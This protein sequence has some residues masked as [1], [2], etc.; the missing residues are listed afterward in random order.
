MYIALTH[1]LLYPHFPTYPV[2]QKYILILYKTTIEDTEL[3]LKSK[4]GKLTKGIE[5]WVSLR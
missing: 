1:N 3:L 5:N 2:M 4:F